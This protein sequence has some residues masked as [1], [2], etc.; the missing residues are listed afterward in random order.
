MRRIDTKEYEEWEKMAADMDSFYRNPKG[1]V[2][3]PVSRVEPGLLYAALI[4]ACWLR[5]ELIDYLEDGTVRRIF[6]DCAVLVLT[7]R[8]VFRW[9]YPSWTL[10]TRR[11]SA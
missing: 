1:A 6:Q 8:F 4:D 9:R 2:M 7:L 11:R 3:K 5:V 10:L